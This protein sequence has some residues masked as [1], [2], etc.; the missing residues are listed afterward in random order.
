MVEKKV[1]RNSVKFFSL[2][3]A[4][5]IVLGLINHTIA[6]AIGMSI[7]YVIS[8]IV[9]KMTVL[10]V[11]AILEHQ[12]KAYS[13]V[14]IFVMLLGKY[15]IYSAGILLGIFFKEYVNFIAVFIG[16]FI[17]NITIYANTIAERRKNIG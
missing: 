6:Y 1:L 8:L 14:L 16:Y 5:T 9:F 2:A 17:V 12:N 15:M 11:D 13:N 10:R 7:G 4:I 3:L